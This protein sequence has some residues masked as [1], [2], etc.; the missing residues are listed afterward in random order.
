MSLFSNLPP[1]ETKGEDEG[2]QRS[3]AIGGGGGG[4]GTGSTV[5][6]RPEFAPNLRR[7]RALGKRPAAVVAEAAVPQL[8]PK[9][10]HSMPQN[11]EALMTKWGAAM[12]TAGSSKK[13]EQT[14]G[15]RGRRVSS[16]SHQPSDGPAA[17]VSLAE[18][19]PSA[20]SRA[21]GG[22][23]RASRTG[24]EPYAEYCPSA[25][26]DYQAYRSWRVQQKNQ[27]QAEEE[28]E[29]RVRDVGE[30]S[31]RIVLTNMADEVDSDLEAE[32]RQECEAFGEVV[33]CTALLSADE[34][35]GDVGR[36]ERVRVVVEF[37]ELAAAVRAREALDQRF[38]AGRHIS[39][40]FV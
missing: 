29:D 2:P 22:G 5:W 35:G 25:P 14:G 30:P 12:A 8:N 13:L 21:R 11:P 23:R 28:E 7:P 3:Q 34:G 40:Q 26:N 18:H 17:V 4:G 20:L 9:H 37:G 27:P 31:A 16:S 39:A 33:R 1:I 24:F 6:A 19:L 15:V 38:F 36:F 10:P 32:T